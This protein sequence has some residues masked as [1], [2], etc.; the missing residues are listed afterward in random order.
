MNGIT[1]YSAS[2]KILYEMPTIYKDCKEK[3]SLM[4]EDYIELHFS[5]LEPIFFG[6]GSW[7]VWNDK[8][9][10]ITSHQQPTANITTGG[11]DY[12][13]KF[14]AYYI[15]WK[16]RIYKAKVQNVKE[17]KFNYTGN[18]KA[19]LKF[20][21]ER[22]K[23]EGFLFNNE[24]EYTYDTEKYRNEKDILENVKTLSFDGDNFIDVLN[25][26]A[27]EWDTE[28]W[29]RKNVIYLGKC[30]ENNTESVDFELYKNVAEMSSSKSEQNYATRLYAFGGTQNLPHNWNKGDAE[31]EVASS[32]TS[33]KTF[34][35]KQDIVSSYF[36][37]KYIKRTYDK[38][39]TIFKTSTGN[40]DTKNS[41]YNSFSLVSETNKIALP[42]AQYELAFNDNQRIYSVKDDV[43]IDCLSFKI[44]GT[45]NEY[46]VL[47]F[48]RFNYE[49][50]YS[51]KKA[52]GTAVYGTLGSGT[53]EY[54][55]TYK[56]YS[57]GIIVRVKLNKF[58]LDEDVSNFYLS[59][60]I[61]KVIFTNKTNETTT[62]LDY[63]GTLTIS[64]Y[65]D[66]VFR[67]SE[68]YNDITA[69][70]SFLDENDKEEPTIEAIFR[71]KNFDFRFVSDSIKMPL[72]GAKFHIKNIMNS[73]LPSQYFPSNKQ[74][75]GIIKAMAE[76]RL[77]LPEGYIQSDN[78][79][80]TIVEKVVTYDDI[81]PNIKAPITQIS[82]EQ[83][84]VLAEDGVTITG[85]TYT[86]YSI[87]QSKYVYSN[88]FKLPDT[89]TLQ[90]V[91]QTG[92]LSGLTF[93]VEYN[94]KTKW[95]K[96]ERKQ[97]DGGLYLP[98]TAMHPKEGDEFIL[99][100]WDSSRIGDLGLIS[101]AQERL[102]K[103]AKNELENMTTEP[104]TY[105]CTMYSDVSYGIKPNAE[106]TDE[107]GNTLIVNEDD[108]NII[109]ND[110]ILN[111]S[112][113][114][115]FDLGQRVTLKNKAF[116]Q[117]GYRESRIIGYEKYMD[118]PY[119]SPQYEVGEKAIYSKLKDLQQQINNK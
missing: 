118:I 101:E 97:F 88:E 71:T 110:T 109:D 43:E 84:N 10:Y 64:N 115:N 53:T 87:L 22:L 82:K 42:H 52:N 11:Y 5:L 46:F 45:K 80:T 49:V 89:E 76:T 31:F 9:Y 119:D 55:D 73:K 41:S 20:F 8:R 107:D 19:H 23:D 56:L 50:H 68:Y 67:V 90:I 25:K 78:K 75:T 65:Y 59:I 72:V 35:T 2:G 94:E 17:T 48:L 27:S 38:E 4:S 36:D 51:A 28:W 92:S 26:F 98:S 37:S 83:K 61:N 86:E 79:D 77:C 103:R 54:Y 81:Y 95:F 39:K 21:V 1:I 57:K 91:F 18:A 30:E 60:H 32:N 85:E 24:Q 105:T 62:T 13:L 104:S 47:G 14:D 70:L 16:L 108:I 113:A 93:D 111:S 99:V 44:N 15:A 33:D 96:I 102:E 100:G 34:K 112:Y 3:V 58:T 106:I 12:D 116:F 6:V 7:C 29:V 69:K 40:I 63:K 74:D 114:L 66:I 117:N